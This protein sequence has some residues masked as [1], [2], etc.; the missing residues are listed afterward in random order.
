MVRQTNRRTQRPALGGPVDGAECEGGGEDGH[1]AAHRATHPHQLLRRQVD[2]LLVLILLVV[3]VDFVERL[4]NCSHLQEL[5]GS[6]K[7]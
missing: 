1:E 2:P 4:N 6:A 3:V 7:R 5:Q